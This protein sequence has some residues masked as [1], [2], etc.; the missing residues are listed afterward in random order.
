[1]DSADKLERGRAAAG[2]LQ[3]PVFQEC[4]ALLDARYIEAWKA[5]KTV[6]L[7]EDAHKYTRLLEWLVADITSILNTG[8]LEEQRLAALEGRAIPLKLSEHIR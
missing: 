8:T 2:L 6:E 3:N 5:A 4:L 1:M 7:R